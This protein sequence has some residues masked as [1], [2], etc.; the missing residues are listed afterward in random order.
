M[1]NSI[2]LK[3]LVHI[4]RGEILQKNNDAPIQFVSTD[5]RKIINGPQT[6]F[7]ALQGFKVDGHEFLEA[8]SKQGVSHFIVEKN[9]DP[10]DYPNANI[11]KVKNT[12]SAMQAL[13]KW[14]RKQFQGPVI[15]ITGSNGKTIIKEWLGQLLGK[16]FDIAKSPKS[17]NSQTGVPLSIFG[18]ESHHKAAILEAGISKPGE[19][20]KLE[21]M[22]KP[23]VGI[24]TN[25]GTAHAE[26]FASQDEKLQEKALLFKHAQ[27]IIYR[28]DH[29]LIHDYLSKRFSSDQ[30]I[31]WSQEPGADFTL[32]VKKEPTGSKITL[33]KPDMGIFTFHSKFNDEASLENLRH[34]IMAG[35]TLGLTEQ[36]IQQT[37][38]QLN[39]IEMRLTLKSG[40]NQCLLI[41]DTYNN[42]LAG[43]DIA[44]EFLQNQRPKK[45][46]VLILSDLLQAGA[47][48]KVY[49]KVSELIQHYQ[50]DLLIA[51]GNDIQLLKQDPPC[52]SL[53]FKDTGHLLGAIGRLN[54]QNDLVL[55]K[56][57]RAFRFE[58]IVNALQERLHGT[59][60]EIN[61]NALRKNFIFYKKQLKPET[62]VMVMV[63]AFAYGGGATE[64]AHHL[65][66]LNA[67]Y[68]AVAYTDE[69]VA[70]R[71]DKIKL[72][73]M[74]LNP[75]PES[76]GNL[77]KFRLEPV[78][79]SLSFF[80]RLGDFCR[81]NLA[82]IKVHL[83]LDTGMHRLGFDEED[84]EELHCLVLEY[85]ELEIASLYT[86]LAGA[87]EAIHKEF[88][89]KQIGRFKTMAEK[90]KSFLSYTPIMHALN[91][92]GIIRYPEHQ[93]DMV[94]LGIGLYGVEVNSIH[95][96]ALQPISVLKTTVSQI[97][98]LKKG[99]SVGY[100]RKGT[101]RQDGKIATIAIGY[102]DGYDRR[103]SNGQGQVLIKGKKAAVIGN[104][105]MDMTMVDVTGMEVE[106][107]DEVIVYGP[108]LSLKEQ[109]STIGT[110]PYEL[111]TNI[112]SR[113]K[114]VYYLD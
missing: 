53:F 3:D 55:I 2:T 91:S 22:I 44:L 104:I 7:I 59:V 75:A 1:I 69:G 50:L 79:Y 4:V 32:A 81:A 85:P 9:I 109:A 41:D 31:S 17:Y 15:G 27:Y 90:I 28:K 35:L 99:E 96:E 67:D 100:S 12:L 16:K 43:L 105:C 8:A 73:I 95:E 98:V 42:D 113:V 40:I 49:Q 34:T 68:L 21:A 11:I 5:S 87:D 65:E 56:G 37:I 86:H 30:L 57:A 54:L 107:G 82:S 80:R 52:E 97:K 39:T 25:I 102:A 74:V 38:P 111:L 66:Q 24:F 84:L 70:L 13:A 83:D 108:G 14:N 45:R 36:E 20:A 51:V 71:Q 93:L 103:F 78:V 6:L 26:G 33:I 29:Q 64:I 58:D 92:A 101:M 72:P 18:I 60:L 23:N 61:L 94:R 19:M 110:I 48:E 76:F 114:R 77:I 46:K 10:N 89:L 63:K 47:K 62:K 112:S 106:E 88:S